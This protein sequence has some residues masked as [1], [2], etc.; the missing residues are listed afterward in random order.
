LLADQS[1]SE[2]FQTIWGVTILF[3]NRLTYRFS[4]EVGLSI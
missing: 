3:V 2:V 1:T 4:F